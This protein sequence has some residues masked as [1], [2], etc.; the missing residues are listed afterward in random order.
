MKTEN[1]ERKPEPKT[2]PVDALKRRVQLMIYVA[3]G[4][5]ALFVL[6]LAEHARSWARLLPMIGV[7]WFLYGAYATW[8]FFTTKPND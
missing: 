2:T 7:L 3:I 5:L 4:W 6:V 1:G 8:K